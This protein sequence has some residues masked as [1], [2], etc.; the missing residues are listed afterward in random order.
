MRGLAKREKGDS[1]VTTTETETPTEKTVGDV[2][3]R[4]KDMGTVESLP[5]ASLHFDKTYQRDL[6]AHFAQ[7]LAQNWEQQATQLPTVSRRSNGSLYVINGQHRIAAATLLGL[8][9]VTC[10][11]VTGLSRQQEADLRL[12]TNVS[13]GESA[14]ER[15]QAKVAANHPDAVEILEI[16]NRFDTQI[17]T[18]PN[19][20]T[21]LNSIT[22]VE[23][24]YA[25]DKGITL[26]RVFEILRD[27][28]GEI[29]PKYATA[30]MMKALAW[31]MEVHDG[32]YNRGR[33]VE[34]L[35]VVG[36]SALDRIMRN[37]RA[38]MGGSMWLN[39][40]RAIVEIYNDRMADGTRLMFRTAGW[41][42]KKNREWND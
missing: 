10:I 28:W 30:H 26:V 41:S 42:S 6:R 11:V 40:Y 33:L 7:K 19:A 24:L 2:L 8:T 5:I 20:S 18:T 22:S 16:C 13:L 1:E 23:D 39:Q 36:P 4:I 35:R 31:F 32:D 38:A 12:H 3:G 27:T 17:N 21:G 37:H 9:E 15:F 34:R 14:L 29:S 25:K